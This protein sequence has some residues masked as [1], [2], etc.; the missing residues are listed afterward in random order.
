MCTLMY[1]VHIFTRVP[2]YHLT[3]T[4]PRMN[5]NRL[6]R[7]GHI[8]QTIGKHE[9][10]DRSNIFQNRPI[11]AK[12]PIVDIPS[13]SIKIKPISYGKDLQI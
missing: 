1:S 3:Y 4:I 5:S 12:S 2:L 7:N 8:V 9:S 13:T 10:A 11:K 6:P